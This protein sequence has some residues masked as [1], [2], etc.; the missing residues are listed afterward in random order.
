V[1][2]KRVCCFGGSFLGRYIFC[3]GNVCGVRACIV[4]V[5]HLLESVYC[6]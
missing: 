6:V 5:V 1:W 2:G 4:L 3:V